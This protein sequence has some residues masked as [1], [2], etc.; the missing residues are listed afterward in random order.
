MGRRRERNRDLP[1]NIRLARGKYYLVQVKLDGKQK[2][3]PLGADRDAAIA[4]YRLTGG[5]SQRK[6]KRI[7]MDRELLS[8]EALAALPSTPGCGLYFLWAG[9]EIQYI[10][11]SVDIKRRVSTHRFMKRVQFDRHTVLE[12]PPQNLAIAEFAYVSKFKPPMNLVA[13]GFAPIRDKLPV[14]ERAHA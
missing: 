5:L 4:A 14:R 7:A 6:L 1:T 3:H 2:W 9:N 10:G 11:R 13:P 12:L 8:L